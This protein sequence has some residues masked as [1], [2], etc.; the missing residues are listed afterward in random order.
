MVAHSG[1]QLVRFCAAGD[2]A[3]VTRFT[4]NRVQQPQRYRSLTAAEECVDV[5]VQVALPVTSTGVVDDNGALLDIE[6]AVMHILTNRTESVCT[7][8]QSSSVSVDTVGTILVDEE[9]AIKQTGI[10]IEQFPSPPPPPPSLV[11]HP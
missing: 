3:D 10:T 6:T 5:Q 8:V 7:P 1:A 2:C 4:Y 9:T 11:C